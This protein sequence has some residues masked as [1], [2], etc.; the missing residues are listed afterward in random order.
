MTDEMEGAPLEVRPRMLTFSQARMTTDYEHQRPDGEITIALF[1]REQTVPSSYPSK[2][3]A[4]HRP[5]SEAAPRSYPALRCADEAQS[6]P[7]L[8]SAV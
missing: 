1:A 7:A 6:A 5:L 4:S 2:S 8:R 3:I